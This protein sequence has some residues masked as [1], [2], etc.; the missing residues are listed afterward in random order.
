MHFVSFGSVSLMPQAAV[1]VRGK[2]SRRGRGLGTNQHMDNTNARRR[3]CS[4]FTIY[5]HKSL[6]NAAPGSPGRNTEGVD[7]QL[8]PGQLPGE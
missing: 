6:I 2:G 8:V 1:R 4:Q 5:Q 7:Y 3:Q